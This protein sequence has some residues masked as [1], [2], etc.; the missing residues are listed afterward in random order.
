MKARGIAANS[1]LALG[2][3]VASKAGALLVVLLAA[4]LLAME[5]FAVVAT[6]LACASLLVSALDLGAGTLLTRDGA[7]DPSSRGALFRDLLLGR[8]PL[9]A[10]LL[11]AA[12][13][14][15]L[16]LGRPA[17]AVAVVAFAL[18]GAFSLSV[19]GVYRSC[20]D[21]RPEALQRLAAAILATVSVGLCGVLVPRAEV[22]LAA[23]ALATLVAS[24]PLVVRLPRVADLSGPRSARAALR[25]TAPI[26]LIALATVAYYRSGT[27][28]LA[29][30]GDARETA[31][32]SVAASLAF[33]L[34]L[35]PNAIT[36]ALLPRLALEES[37]GSLVE[38]TRRT[39]VWTLAIA[40]GV[41]AVAAALAPV[42]LPVLIG[43]E[44]AS[45]SY[46][47]ALLCV[48]IP[49]IATSG[50]IGTAVLA[51]GRLRLLGAQVAATLVLNLGALAV[52]APRLGSIGA[53]LATVICELGG[54]VLLLLVARR[55]LPGLAPTRP[56]WAGG[57]RGAERALGA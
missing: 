45:A 19:L 2:G 11:L 38:C 31:I 39:L 41:A 13:V 17:V 36:T 54:L 52:L 28:V 21:L 44:Y 3:D 15:G 8:A 29:L 25:R 56:R 55:V 35:I 33:G 18:S 6:A 47:F 20:R 9:A 48:G 23:L 22:V 12:P 43:S 51:L 5:E 16:W 53:A 4:R 1:L 10:A 42:A 30:C 50:V 14:V 24:I 46:P 34:L 26:G 40:L 32:F 49:I 57:I 27:V 37:L 7:P